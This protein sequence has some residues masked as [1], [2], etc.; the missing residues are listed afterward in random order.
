[1]TDQPTVTVVESKPWYESK[2][3]IS[4]A[5]SVTLGLLAAFGKK[6]DIPA[7]GMTD[8]ILALVSAGAGVLAMIF[9]ATANTTLTK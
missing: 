7:E 6:L 5:V 8:A 2:T 1:M 3:I 9:R 4:T